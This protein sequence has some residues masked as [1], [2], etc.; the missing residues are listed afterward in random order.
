MDILLDMVTPMPENKS[1]IIFKTDDEKISIDVRVDKE[2]V[3]LTQQQIA[4][5]F[6]TA[7]TNVVEHIKHIYDDCELSAKATCQDFRQVRDEGGRQVTRTLPHYNLD[8]IIS[9]GYRVNSKIA[10]KFRQWATERLKEYMIK[11]FTLDD[12]RL[13][14][15][16]GRYF[17]ELLQRVRDIRSSE[18]NLWQQ[19]TDIYATSIDY[20]PKADIT[21]DFFA[22]VQNK[23]HYAVHQQTAAEVIYNRVDNKKAMVGMTAFKGNYITKDDVKIAKNYLS[24]LELQ[25]LNL[26]TEGFL[27]YAELQ[28]LEHNPMTMS[29][30]KL[31]LD[32]QL[33]MLN[34]DILTGRGNIS[35]EKAVKKAENEFEIYR[36]REMKQTI[37]DFDRA[38]KELTLSKPS[39]KDGGNA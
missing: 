32:K 28:A 17:R 12:E 24:E 14:N 6:D 5:L 23:M 30:W 20:N 22:T 29:D 3:W 19:V 4:E 36:A 31:F 34:K 37:S 25:K 39:L 11:G 35:H 9:L 16:G 13:K 21:R 15:G 10:T 33:T 8:M 1:I 2:T 7:R 18:R 26:L 27:G 38:V